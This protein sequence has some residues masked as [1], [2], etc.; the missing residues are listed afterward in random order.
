[1]NLNYSQI[2]EPFDV[3]KIFAFEKQNIVQEM[4]KRLSPPKTPRD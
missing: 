4:V 1:M 3:P 2:T